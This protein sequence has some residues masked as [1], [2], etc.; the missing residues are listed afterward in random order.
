MSGKAARPMDRVDGKLKVTGVAQYAAD[1]GAEGMLYGVP[2]GSTIARGRIL[3]MN[4][5][6]AE[7][8]PGVAA[9]ISRRT[10]P[11]LKMPANDFGSWT[12]LGEARLLFADDNI[13]YAGQYVALVVAD[14]LEHATAAAALVDISY[15]E[16]K[17]VVETGN[18]MDTLFVPKAV[19]GPPHKARGNVDQALKTARFRLDQNYSTPIEHHNP[20]EPSATVAVWHN[21]NLTLYDATQWVMGARNCVADMLDI[22]RERVTIVSEFVGGGFGCKGFIWPHQVLAAIAA[23]QVGRPVKVALSRRQMYSACG[24]RPETRQQVTLGADDKGRL[25]AIRHSSISQ[26]STVDEH[27]ELCGVATG[28]LYDCPNVETNH[29]LLRVNI[30]TPTPMRAPG[31]SPGMFAT[32]SAL[33]ELSYLAG[34]DPVELRLRNY[35]ETDPDVRL[36]FSGK[37]L[38]ACYEIGRER[39]GWN[40]RSREPRSMRDGRYLVGY[41]MATA[42]YPAYRSPG[43]A[44]VRLHDDGIVEVASAT[45]DIG[46]GTYTTM[47]QIAS[48]TLG[49][50]ASQIHASLGDSR[51]PPAPVSGGSMTTASVTPAVKAA[52][53]DAL[54]KLA[55]MGMK[56]GERNYAAILRSKGV[57]Q[58]EGHAQ[59]QPGE[60]WAKF[61]FHSFG[62]QFAQV[63]VDPELGIVEVQRMVSVFDIGR[64][65]NMKTARSQAYGGI[66]Q[67]IGMA[68]ME[69]TIYDQRNG[70]IVSDNLADY[71][72]PVNADIHHIDVSFVD[73]PDM[74]ISSVGAR[75]MGEIAITGVAPAIANAV[76]HATGIRVRD[77]P[78]TIEKLLAS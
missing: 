46:T 73:I 26:T 15:E 21:D 45:Q 5:E 59:V 12:K 48:E 67:G 30:A 35:A 34:L 42:T 76:Y 32:E 68:L 71:L 27:T 9:V 58:I 11:R 70:A 31:E 61:S 7:K 43:A 16:Q 50:P 33:D 77:L 53:E 25:V 17:P 2:A 1:R 18:A 4:T 55:Q 52:C 39:I 69:H 24:H 14:T 22:N 47:T 23:K 74:N 36:P 60:E 38:R 37:H 63:R 29:Q 40:Q 64:V 41:G 54:R 78:I 49:I 10:M 75:G 65:L 66:T 56:D 20:M 13:H 62:A 8:S 19:F 44:L 51:L 28:F 57:K 6:R 3:A 72:L